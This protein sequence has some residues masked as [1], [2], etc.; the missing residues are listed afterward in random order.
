M[1]AQQTVLLTIIPRG[2]SLDGP[3]MPVSVFVSPRLMGETNLGE[4]P[5][6]LRWTLRLQRNGLVLEVRCA[7]QSFDASIDTAVLRPDLWRQLFNR[8]TLVR[9]HKF[10]DYSDRGVISF[11]VR[12][13]LSALKTIYQEAGLDLALPD[14]GAR[15]QE[16]GNRTRLRELVDGLDVHWNG[17]R[18][19]QWREWVRGMNAPTNLSFS[20]PALRGP[21]DREGLFV[22]DR[23]PAALQRVAVPFAVFHHMPTPKR[24]DKELPLDDQLDKDNLLDFHQALSSLNAYPE[25]QRALGL[26]FDLEL[27]RAFVKETGVSQVG[28]LSTNAR[29]WGSTTRSGT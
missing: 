26:V 4:F 24:E 1:A 25:L 22:I 15:G 27:P 5:D 12:D 14:S 23:T 10:N 29:H 21:L 19:K 8:D 16:R 11:S 3:T 9:S 13:A 2:V 18:A 6:W 17:D 7:G 28:T 20:Q